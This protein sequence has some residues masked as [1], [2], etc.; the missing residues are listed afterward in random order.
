[1]IPLANDH[2]HIHRR[3]A[4]VNFIWTVRVTSKV[5]E[6]VQSHLKGRTRADEH[7]ALLLWVAEQI[8][9]DGNNVNFLNVVV[10]IIVA[11]ISFVV[12]VVVIVV[13]DVIC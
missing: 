7:A 13:A 5:E 2:H 6:S 11:F 9:F 4:Q 12:V 1:M 8:K 10:V 3:I